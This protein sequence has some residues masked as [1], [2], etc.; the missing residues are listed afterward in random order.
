MIQNKRNLKPEQCFLRASNS[1]KVLL[2][3]QQAAHF[4]MHVLKSTIKNQA[5]PLYF[6]EITSY[7]SSKQN[8]ITEVWL[9]GE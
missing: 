8:F 4:H 2:L 1:R 5:V 6:K 7:F 3:H 9:A